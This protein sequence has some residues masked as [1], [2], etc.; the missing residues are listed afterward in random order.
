MSILVKII[1]RQLARAL[2]YIADV[3]NVQEKYEQAMEKEYG[4]ASLKNGRSA[5]LHRSNIGE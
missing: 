5:G 1:L 3:W 4:T 2:Y